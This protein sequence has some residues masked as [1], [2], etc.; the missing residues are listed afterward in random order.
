[1]QFPDNVEVLGKNA[2][3]FMMSHGMELPASLQDF[4]LAAMGAPSP[5]D[6]I[7]KF[8]EAL[9][10]AAADLDDEGKILCAQ[11]IG[12]ASRN[13][14]HGLAED[15]RGGRIVMAMRRQLGE[16]SPSGNWPDPEDDP[17]PLAEYTAIDEVEE[18]GEA[19]IPS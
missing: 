14:W 8:G 17:A 9:Y 7:V 19:D 12:F 6:R 3:I 4:L 1:M 5:V 18:A 15:N 13:G 16:T 11:M 10:A 2:Q